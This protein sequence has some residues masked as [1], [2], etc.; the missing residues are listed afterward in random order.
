M[1]RAGWEGNEGYGEREEG[2]AVGE[3]EWEEV[4]FRHVADPYGRGGG[5]HGCHAYPRTRSKT[6][7]EENV[8]RD[9]A[10]RDSIR[11]ECVCCDA[12][13]LWTLHMEI[14]DAG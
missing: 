8:F 4:V 10:D 1:A 2:E 12:L 11:L 7:L 14:R 9:D 13:N 5:G 3:V 6:L